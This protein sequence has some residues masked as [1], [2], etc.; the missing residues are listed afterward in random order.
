MNK[1]GRPPISGVPGS[2]RIITTVSL[3]PEQQIL[4]RRL[5]GSPWIREQIERAIKERQTMRDETSQLLDDILGAWHQYCRSFQMV[6]EPKTSAMFNGIRSS[7]QWD[8]ENEILEDCGHKDKMKAVDFHIGELCDV[9]R[10]AL[11]INAR[12]ICTGKNVW[13]SARLPKDEKERALVLLEARTSLLIRLRNAGVI[14][15]VNT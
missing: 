2:R 13:M 14:Y 3:K 4:L 11:C 1:G 8:S 9:Y 7:R 5:G 6:A 10:T 12:N 15:R